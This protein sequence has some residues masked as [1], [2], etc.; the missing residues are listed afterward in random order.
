[1]PGRLTLITDKP[2]LEIP[3]RAFAVGNYYI[4]NTFRYGKKGIRVLTIHLTVES[5]P[6]VPVIV[7]GMYRVIGNKNTVMLDASRTIDPDVSNSQVPNLQYTWKGN[8]TC[9]NN[10]VGWSKSNAKLQIRNNC[11]LAYREHSFEV[12]VKRRNKDG[13][14]GKVMSTTQKV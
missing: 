4:Q 10:T 5:T 3:P 8:M 7:G 12:N 11:L 1:M 14:D 13:K 2:V 6:L 9:L